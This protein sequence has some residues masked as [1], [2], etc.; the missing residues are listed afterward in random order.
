MNILLKLSVDDRSD[1]FFLAVKHEAI[2]DK[3]ANKYFTVD[4]FG[5]GNDTGSLNLVYA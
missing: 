1:S 2:V 5:V 3:A 4:K